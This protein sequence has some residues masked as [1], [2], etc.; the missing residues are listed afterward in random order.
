MIHSRD[1]SVVIQ[2]P[3]EWTMDREHGVGVTIALSRQI[4]RLL[5]DAEIILSTWKGQKRDAIEYDTLIESKDPG[6]QG[7]WPSFTVNNVN[8][9]IVSTAVG[10]K[11]VTRRYVLKIRSDMVL[12]S[13][14]FLDIFEGTEPLP[15]N[16]RNVFARAVL[17]N[18]FSSRDTAAILKRL[19]GHPLPFHFSDHVSFGLREDV[20]FLWDVPAQGD[21]DSI[22]FMDR[23]QPNRFRLHELARLTPEQY[24]FTSALAKKVPVEIEHYA[25]NRPHIIEQSEYYMTT[26][27]VTVP[28]REFSIYFEKYHTDHH[29]SFEW[30]RRNPDQ[31][32]LETHMR[33]P[34]APPGPSW[35]PKPLRAI[36]APMREPKRIKDRMARL[37]SA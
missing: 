17:T 26:H 29:F 36:T 10:L 11:A 18:N 34:A 12:R 23:S 33:P 1:I 5:P 8:R 20:Q 21:A 35:L 27:I 7:A 15:V 22:F 24:I 3:I 14:R 19:P 4:R 28:D 2:G 16:E 30:M 37:F 6:P 13:T 25:D 31:E 9:Q 32:L